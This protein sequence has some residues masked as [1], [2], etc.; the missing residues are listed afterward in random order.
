MQLLLTLH[1]VEAR[2]MERTYNPSLETAIAIAKRKEMLEML[3]G[4]Y[5]CVPGIAELCNL[6]W[7]GYT[8]WTFLDILTLES[9]E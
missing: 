8:E 4:L 6:S 7:E 1:C 9:Q 3:Q 2:T 5:S